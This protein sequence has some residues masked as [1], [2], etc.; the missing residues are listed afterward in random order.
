MKCFNCKKVGVKENE[1][2]ENCGSFVPRRNS[3]VAEYA[4]FQLDGKSEPSKSSK[5]SA[6]DKRETYSSPYQKW[7]A[8]WQELQKEFNNQQGLKG[9]GGKTPSESYGMPKEAPQSRSYN[10]AI[11]EP[12]YRRAAQ[13]PTVRRNTNRKTLPLP[14]IIIFI[15]IF[16]ATVILP[17]VLTSMRYNQSQYQYV[18]DYFPLSE[19][20][21]TQGNIEIHE[22]VLDDFKLENIVIDGDYVTSFSI[23]LDYPIPFT[24]KNEEKYTGFSLKGNL[25]VVET[26]SLSVVFNENIIHVPK[27]NFKLD[28]EYNLL[29]ITVPYYN[30]IEESEHVYYL[31]HYSDESAAVVFSQGGYS[32]RY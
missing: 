13:M 31:S 5:Y 9:K 14:G 10:T 1:F 28:T 19:H 18:D 7:A 32:I 22:Y 3:D 4:D 6:N 15:I 26:K 27:C 12:E 21:S 2:C 23:V 30:E 24:T 25:E 8:L 17:G 16:V 20:E 29:Y 11:D